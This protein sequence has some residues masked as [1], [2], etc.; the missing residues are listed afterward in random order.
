MI[1]ECEKC[2]SINVSRKDFNIDLVS[3]S[4]LENSTTSVSYCDDKDQGATV[5]FYKWARED[6]KLKKMLSKESIDSAIRKFKSTIT[7]LKHHMY[8]KHVQFNYYNNIKN[9]LGKSDLLVHVEYS[10]SYENKQQH[11]IQS[12]YFG[13]TTFSIFTACCYLPDSEDNLVSESITVTREL[14]DHSRSTAIACV[15]KVIEN[16]RE[17]HQYLP[18]RINVFVWRDGCAAQ[19][20]SRCVLYYYQL[21]MR[22]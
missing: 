15:S 20:R 16:V 18:L 7:K 6:T 9:N 13:H 12:A 2:S 22:H 21:S 1:G 4:D 3:D 14:P 11:E 17:N 10:E 5:A 19:F 8:V